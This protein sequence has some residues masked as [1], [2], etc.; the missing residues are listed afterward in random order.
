MYIPVPTSIITETCHPSP[1]SGHLLKTVAAIV[2]GSAGK[3]T[4]SCAISSEPVDTPDR[5]GG[6]SPTGR[7]STIYSVR[8]SGSIIG[9]QSVSSSGSDDYLTHCHNMV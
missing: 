2:V 6:T 8:W 3:L 7:P 1:G 9:T 4:A 5:M